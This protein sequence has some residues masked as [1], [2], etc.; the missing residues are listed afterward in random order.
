MYDYGRAFSKS[1]MWTLGVSLFA[2]CENG[3]PLLFGRPNQIKQAIDACAY[4]YRIASLERPD[5][6]DLMCMIMSHKVD[7][8]ASV[9][10]LLASP[11]LQET[12]ENVF[13]GDPSKQAEALGNTLS[14]SLVGD[15]VSLCE[16]DGAKAVNQTE[17]GEI[18]FDV[19]SD[20][21]STK[22]L[23]EQIVN[24]QNR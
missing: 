18:N 19:L 23:I 22:D 21:G 16:M 2:L 8:R 1:D 15:R 20:E 17:G 24:A 6:E 5:I 10:E 14:I 9:K 3:E 11:S 13:G 4:Y 7:E 12:L